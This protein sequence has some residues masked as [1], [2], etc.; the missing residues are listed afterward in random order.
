MSAQ[1]ARPPLADACSLLY[2]N[3]SWRAYLERFTPHAPEY[4]DVFSRSWARFFGV[5]HDRYRAALDD[6]GTEQAIGTLL[7]PGRPPIDLD[8]LLAERAAQ[9][10]V[11]EIALGSMAR[12]PDGSTVNDRLLAGTAAYRR[13]GRERVWVWAGLTLGGTDD[14]LAELS[15][16]AAA[17]ARGLCVIPFLDGIEADDPRFTP[18]FGAAE[19]AGLPVWLHTGHHFAAGRPTGLGSWRLVETLARRHP[20]LV[21]VAGH[22]GWPD[23]M[24]MLLTA[25]RHRNVYLEFSSHRARTMPALGSGWAP[26]LHHARSLARHRVMFGTSAWVNPQPVGALAD[27]VIALG[28]AEEITAEWLGGTA[29]RLLGAAPAVS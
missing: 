23:V 5:P 22:A 20:R 17:G 14:P 24:E 19:D 9:G 8:A 1:G 29:L 13:P 26:L 3:D 18:V 28:L 16:T 2:D 12:L 4:L 10:V 7:P 15:R 11:A 25:A 27:E 6:G 21:I